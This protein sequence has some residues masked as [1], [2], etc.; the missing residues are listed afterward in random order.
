MYLIP[1][2]HH[3]GWG[4]KPKD[5]HKITRKNTSKYYKRLKSIFREKIRQRIQRHIHW[6]QNLA[7]IGRYETYQIPGGRGRGKVGTGS[8]SPWYWIY[9]P[10]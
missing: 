4:D 10:I 6:V 3:I 1:K 7:M 5:T 8:V 2:T 9:H